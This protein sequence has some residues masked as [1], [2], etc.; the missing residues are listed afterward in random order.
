VFLETR[1]L[2]EEWTFRFL[3]AAVAH[4]RAERDAAQLSGDPG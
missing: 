3:G 2:A 1:T 4:A